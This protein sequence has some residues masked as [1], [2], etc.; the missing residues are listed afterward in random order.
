MVARK[1]FP[2]D[3]ERM[4]EMYREGMSTRA[5]ARELGLSA[6]TV[7]RYLG[8]E[9]VATRTE[10]VEAAVRARVAV[11]KDRLARNA[12]E[13]LDDVA[14]LRDRLYERCE[15]AMNGPEGVSVVELSE[16]P[17]SDVAQALRASATAVGGVQRVLERLDT[18]DDGAAGSVVDD[19][20]NGLRALFSGESGSEGVDLGRDPR[21]Y[22]G[23]YDIQ[24]DPEVWDRS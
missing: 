23:D 20:V 22:D 11:L 10:G 15:V 24:K 12:V 18:G 8:R 7:S 19:L 13:T 6:T 9:V 2:E 4:A 5:I 16:P 17:I 3:S 1:V 14:N 21:D